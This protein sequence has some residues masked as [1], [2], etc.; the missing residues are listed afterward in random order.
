MVEPTDPALRAFVPMSFDVPNG[1]TVPAHVRSVAAV[2]NP[3]KYEHGFYA[4]DTLSDGPVD[5]CLASPPTGEN[6]LTPPKT[7]IVR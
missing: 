2:T 5:D 7:I 4:L 6:I 3:P 1:M